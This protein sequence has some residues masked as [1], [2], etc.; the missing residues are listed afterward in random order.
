[1]GI[2]VC[3]VCGYEGG[4]GQP[5]GHVCHPSDV[6]LHVRELKASANEA[7][8]QIRDIQNA[9]FRILEDVPS[10]EGGTVEVKT[11]WLRR[12]WDAA[13][14]QRNED[15]SLDNF[16]ARWMSMH[17]IM[18]NA[19]D[20][21]R[22]RKEESLVKKLTRLRQQCDHAMVVFGYNSKLDLTPEEAAKS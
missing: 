3:E 19:F 5:G 11:E 6:L 18:A 4:L 15:S 22:F 13:R 9:V 16:L 20:V 14:C 2:F 8:L 17:R 12:L 7:H 1:M 21:F 10:L